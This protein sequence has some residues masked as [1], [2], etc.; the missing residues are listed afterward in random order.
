MIR[1][2]CRSCWFKIRAEEDCA[3]KKVKCPKC[4]QV[5]YVPA[6]GIRTSRPE[7]S[8][9]PH[10][11]TR[12]RGSDDDASEE[13]DLGASALLDAGAPLSAG[14]YERPTAESPGEAPVR[15]KRDLASGPPLELPIP[16]LHEMG[17]PPAPPEAPEA[18]EASLAGT[19]P[20]G[21]AEDAAG[22]SSAA[23]KALSEYAKAG[24]PRVAGARRADRARSISPVVIPVVAAVV[25]LVTALT[26]WLVL[27]DTWEQDH[28]DQ[29]VA[30]AEEG[31]SLA[32]E[33]RYEEAIQKHQ[34]ILDLIGM[35]EIQDPDL[36]AELRRSEEAMDAAKAELTRQKAE[37]KA[38]K[39]DQDL[40]DRRRRTVLA[41]LSK[42]RSAAAGGQFKAALESYKRAIDLVEGSPGAVVAL[43]T[44][45]QQARGER[46]TVRKR[47]L[48]LVETQLADVAAKA[49][50]AFDSGKLDEAER[51]CQEAI[52]L[53]TASEIQS[54]KIRQIGTLARDLLLRVRAQKQI[55]QRRKGA[56]RAKAQQEALAAR[57]KQADAMHARW[58]DLYTVAEAVYREAAVAPTAAAD[59]KVRSLSRSLSSAYARLRKPDWVS[60]GRALRRSAKQVLASLKG[61]AKTLG[62]L[63]GGPV[64]S[65]AGS[66]DPLTKAKRA[67]LKL[68]REKLKRDV[69]AFVGDYA[70][71]V[72]SAGRSVAAEK[73]PPDLLQAGAAQR[74]LRDRCKW[75]GGTGLMPCPDCLVKGLPSGQAKCPRCSGTGRLTCSTCGGERAV[76]AVQGAGEGLRGHEEDRPRQGAVVL[77]HVR[78]VQRRGVYPHGAVATAPGPMPHVQ[79]EPPEGNRPLSA[80]PRERAPRALPH[81][82]GPEEGSVHALWCALG[83]PESARRDEGGAVAAR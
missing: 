15:G 54:E 12:R 82:Q 75:C 37:E 81:V 39:R 80:V 60:G 7:G 30:L 36:L 62:S 33:K 3:G 42:A 68:S 79:D 21:V 55:E 20:P 23:R 32:A 29:V 10:K 45:L 28:Y 4:G 19:A 2:F 71:F 27:R 14:M 67:K 40:L 77:P 57:K 13:L 26:L 74:K 50:V 72:T 65:G 8:E 69:E 6:T 31:N 58:R 24:T 48:L 44:T 49:Q 70:A 9:K 41:A 34:A 16:P 22:P 17:V 78:S 61:H 5:N 52:D 1:F 51:R 56:L 63:G 76:P 43:A 25:L 73:I 66:D 83:R 38:R 59:Q 11:K 53:A 46:E 35:R 47:W 18:P 64:H